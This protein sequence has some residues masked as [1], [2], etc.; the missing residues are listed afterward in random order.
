MLDAQNRSRTR[1]RAEPGRRPLGIL[2]TAFPGLV[3]SRP[4]CNVDA[5]ES[6]TMP[7]ASIPLLPATRQPRD[8]ASLSGSLLESPVLPVSERRRQLVG[9]AR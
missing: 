2:A 7:S 6:A 3:G 1:A 4:I 8:P 9:R 5:N